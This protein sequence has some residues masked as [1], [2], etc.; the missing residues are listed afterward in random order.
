MLLHDRLYIAQTKSKSFHVVHISGRYAI[1]LIK[2]LAQMFPGDA[3]PI[4]NERNPE[5]SPLIP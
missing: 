1:E 3:N 5:A 2:N 4:V